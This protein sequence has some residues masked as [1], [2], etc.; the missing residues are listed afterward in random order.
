MNESRTTFLDGVFWYLET[1]NWAFEKI[2]LCPRG[3]QGVDLKMYHYLYFSNL[4]GAIDIVRDYRRSIGETA[5]F[6]EE[7]RSRFANHNDYQY[8][9]ELRNSI[10][11]RGL[12]PAAAGHA[13]DT[14]LYVLCPPFVRNRSG[15]AFSCSFE[16]TV[17]LAEQC[18]SA[19]SAAIYE[20]LHDQGF[21]DPVA[22]AVNKA[23]TLDAIKDS[24]TMPDWAKRMALQALG[25]LNFEQMA[26]TIAAT[27]VANL[28]QLLDPH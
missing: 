12:D 18:N 4:F 14:L 19:A 6:D 10:V 5:D 15:K 1:R 2:R 23:E 11:H 7:V 25:K 27:R 22:N 20:F 3:S 26:T 8:A 13:D 16:Y 21:L 17:Q 9:R 28:K 24:S